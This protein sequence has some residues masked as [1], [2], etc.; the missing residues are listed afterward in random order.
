MYT[1]VRM[2]VLLLFGRF[3]R[4]YT[5]TGHCKTVY[6]ATVIC[7]AVSG[8]VQ[9]LESAQRPLKATAINAIKLYKASNIPTD[10]LYA[11]R[12]ISSIIPSLRPVAKHLV[13]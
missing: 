5:Y 9:A 10:T 12:S 8:A 7:A 2:I 6:T 1:S 13:V 4:T 11:V 3:T